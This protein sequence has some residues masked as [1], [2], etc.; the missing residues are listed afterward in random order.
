M[1]RGRKSTR[2]LIS[3]IFQV[4]QWYELLHVKEKW[5]QGGSNWS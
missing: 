4:I 1:V 5:L 2:K 3:D